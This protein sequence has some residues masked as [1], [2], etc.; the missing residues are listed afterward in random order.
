MIPQ[1]FSFNH[2]VDSAY[3]SY[4]HHRPAS[5][6]AR[7]PPLKYSTPHELRGTPRR[8]QDGE[9][10]SLTSEMGAC[11]RPIYPADYTESCYMEALQE[12]ISGVLDRMESLHKIE[13][14]AALSY[15]VSSLFVQ[16]SS[17]G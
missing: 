8:H 10:A 3:R 6:Q 9:P 1:D 4:Y 7:L 15:L 11:V 12:E 13:G 2:S 17:S 16:K 5:Y 14:V